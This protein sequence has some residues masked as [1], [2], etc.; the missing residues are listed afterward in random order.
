M[1]EMTAADGHS[2]SAYQAD[3]ADAPK[4]VV[5]VLQEVF[6][7]NA[8]IRKLADAFAAQGFL[9]VAPS[10]YDRAEKGV[11]L[12]YDEASVAKGI[13]LIKTVGESPFHDIQATVTT[14]REFGKVAL[15]GFDWG[16]FLAYHTANRVQGIATAVSY[17]GCGIVDHASQRR[18]VPTLMHFGT[19]D[20]Y[21][22]ID[23]ITTFRMGRPDLRI[24]TYAAGHHFACDDRDTYDAAATEKAW[25][26]T[27][28]HLTHIL[29]G[30]PVVTLKNQGA[31]AAVSVGKEKKKKPVTADDDLGPPM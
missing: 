15:V 13:E 4:G 9:A 17:Y 14:F 30:P 6:G 23:Q 20:P 7:V 21:I 12:G 26:Y 28:A 19:L 27:V 25:E 18:K 22:S 16:G 11:E 29:Q 24:C 1:I 3:P 31:Y 10:L 8:H 5:V 2:F